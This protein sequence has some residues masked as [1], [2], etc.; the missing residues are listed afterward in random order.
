MK[1]HLEPSGQNLVSHYGPGLIS[2][3]GKDYHTNVLITRNRVLE[4]W[5]EGEPSQLQMN[6]FDSLLQATREE[7]PEIIVLGTGEQHIF[8]SFQLMAKLKAEGMALEVMN[9]RAACRTYS[10]LVSEYRSVA[11]A[12]LQISDD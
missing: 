7:R 12:L 4:N 8:P 11:A 2:I 10:V 3:N 5:F 6:H 9:T 1:F